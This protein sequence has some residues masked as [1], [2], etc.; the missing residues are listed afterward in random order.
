MDDDLS[1]DK[2]KVVKP[3]RDIIASATGE[4][5]NHL[6]ELVK[7]GTKELVID[8]EHVEMI[9]SVGLGL[10]IATYNSLNKVG[11]QLI[12]VNASDDLFGLFKNMRL[13]QRMNVASKA[14]RG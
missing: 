4:L 1:A 9:D 10:F 5:R 11:G 7:N 3:D 13:D 12:V 2:K 6:N 8:L 14:S